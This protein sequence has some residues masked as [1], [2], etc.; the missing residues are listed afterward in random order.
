MCWG[1]ENHLPSNAYASSISGAPQRCRG[2][3]RAP[4]LRHTHALAGGIPLPIH[5]GRERSSHLLQIGHFWAKHPP[6]H[7]SQRRAT[8]VVWPL[9]CV[10]HGSVRGHGYGVRLGHWRAHERRR[11]HACV[12]N[13]YWENSQKWWQHKHS[14]RCPRFTRVFMR[15][16]CKPVSPATQVAQFNHYPSGVARQY[17]G[18]DYPKHQ[19]P[20]A[21]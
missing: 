7:G 16:T 12:W 18:C 3:S 9:R 17:T 11:R 5:T 19:P 4:Y 21:S 6:H 15:E 1:Q 10:H 13:G 14:P 20:E 8:H 2:G